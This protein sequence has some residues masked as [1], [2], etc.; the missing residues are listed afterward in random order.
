MNIWQLIISLSFIFSIILLWFSM[1]TIRLTLD[2]RIRKAL[3][4]DKV[5]NA[6]PDWYCGL[7]RAVGFGSASIFDFANKSEPI[8]LFYESFDVKSFS[9]PF[10]K[11]LGWIMVLSLFTLITSS[12]IY[13]LL[14]AVGIWA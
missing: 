9:N 7:G 4:S 12:I 2:R 13:L 11:A 6:Y 5:Y 10:E 8:R 1:I 3:P 14:K